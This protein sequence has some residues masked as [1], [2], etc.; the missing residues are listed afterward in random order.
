MPKKINILFTSVGRRS[1]LVKYFKKELNGEGKIHVANSSKDSPAFQFADENVV[2]PLIY[3]K[4]YIDFLLH[5]CVKNN[6][7]VIIPLFDVDL[8]VLSIHKRTFDEIG[9]RLLVSDKKVIDICNDK[10]MTYKYL[11][12]MGIHTPNTYL[13]LEEV[14]NMINCNKCRFPLIIKPRWGMGSIGLYE[15][16]NLTEMKVLYNKL[17]RDISKTYLKYESQRDV[18]NKVIIQ[19][20]VTGSEFGLDIINNLN[21]EYKTTICKI[22]Y[23]MRAGETDCA[24]T[25]YNESLMKLGEIVGKTI[26]HIGNMDVDIIVENGIP[27]I[28]ELNARFGGGYPFSHMSGVNLPMA[29]LSWLRNEEEPSKCLIAKNNIKSHKDIC[30]VELL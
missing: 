22:K 13:S 4:G 12:D 17:D 23:A 5:Y 24:M 11:S 28:L 9:T 15:A 21:K 7:D 16:E 2:T 1:Y 27:Y 14:E 25:I 20:K 19:Q 26:K 3:D 30:M 18:H 8:H 10:Y 6:I 29:I